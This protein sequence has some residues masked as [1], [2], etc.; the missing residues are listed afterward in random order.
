MSLMSMYKIILHYYSIIN[1]H[2]S[3]FKII[4][5]KIN[6]LIIHNEL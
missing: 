3:Y 5:L 1:Y 6:K 2:L 4:I